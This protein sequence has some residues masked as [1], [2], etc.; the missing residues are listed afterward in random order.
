MP[1]VLVNSELFEPIGPYSHVVKAG[2]Q[3]FVSGT[4]G[5][6]P[7]TG[8]LAGQAAYEQSLQAFLNVKAC[9]EAAGGEESDIAHVQVHLVNVGDFSEMNR[10]YAEV[11]SQPYPARTVIGIA[12]LPKAGALLTVN[13]VAVLSAAAMALP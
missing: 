2:H 11:F 4:P 5:V 10:A 1:R 8:L 7:A 9:V 13:A 12:A 6:V 3:I